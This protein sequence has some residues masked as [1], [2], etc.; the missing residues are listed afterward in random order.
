MEDDSGVTYFNPSSYLKFVK[1]SRMNGDE[2][3]SRRD[4]EEVSM[5]SFSDLILDSWSKR[6][7]DR[8]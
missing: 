1:V 4:T 6:F 7:H 3:L 5:F 8:K 2:D